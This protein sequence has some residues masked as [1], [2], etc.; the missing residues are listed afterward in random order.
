MTAED[1]KKQI[2]CAIPFD[3]QYVLDV[4]GRDLNEGLP[5]MIRVTSD[6]IGE[7]IAPIADKIADAV[8]HV[9]ERTPPE[10]VGDIAANGITMTGA[11]SLLYGLDKRIESACGIKTFIADNPSTCVVI[12]TGRSLDNIPVLPEG[13]INISRKREQRL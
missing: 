7:A 4:K 5:K 12:G 13:V 6:E 1:I 10:L 3:K 9:I 8:C 2:G 11:G